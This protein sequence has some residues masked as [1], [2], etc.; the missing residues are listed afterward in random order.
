MDQPAVTVPGPASASDFMAKDGRGGWEA[1]E[2]RGG[3][4]QRCTVKRGVWEHG[5]GSVSVQTQ[6]RPLV[7][8]ATVVSLVSHM[9]TVDVEAE[10]IRRRRKPALS[11]DSLG[12]SS[13]HS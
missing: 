9:N 1:A 8:E 11:W 5:R 3:S 10:A 13:G 7:C 12:A 6:L 2:K 4:S